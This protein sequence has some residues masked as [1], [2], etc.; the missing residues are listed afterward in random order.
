MKASYII[1]SNISEINFTR[2]SFINSKLTFNSF[3]ETTLGTKEQLSYYCDRY[4][5]CWQIC[6]FS[7]FWIIYPMIGMKC[8]ARVD[9]L[10]FRSI[11]HYQK[12]LH[13]QKYTPNNELGFGKYWKLLKPEGQ[14]GLWLFRSANKNFCKQN[15]I[16]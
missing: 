8:V 4:H 13:G 14:L 6:F 15:L 16:L 2:N 12:D 7:T 1:N 3:S 9:R 10:S 5:W 11:W